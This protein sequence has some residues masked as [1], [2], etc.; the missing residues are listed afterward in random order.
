MKTD[1]LDNSILKLNDYLRSQDCKLETTLLDYQKL[2]K[3]LQS[4]KKSNL[5]LVE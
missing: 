4:T 5:E 3:D 2:E 1:Y